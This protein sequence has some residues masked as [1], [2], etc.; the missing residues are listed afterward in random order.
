MRLEASCFSGTCNAGGSRDSVSVSWA[1]FSVLDNPPLPP[2]TLDSVTVINSTA[3]QIDFSEPVD[4]SNIL[5]Y[6]IER[7]NGTNYNVIGNVAQGTTTFDDVNLIPDTFYNY[8][9]IS[10]GTSENSNPSNIV[11]QRTTVILFSSSPDSNIGARW[12][13]GLGLAPC[14]DLTTF[15]CVNE[16]IRDDG[17]F[18]QTIG[19]GSSDSDID[20]F[21]MSDMED[22]LRSDSHFLKYTVRK[23]GVGTNPVEFEIILRQGVTTIATFTHTGLS[24]NYVLIQ[25]ELTGIQADLITDYNDLEIEVTGSCDAGCSNNPNAREK[26]NVSFIIFEIEQVTSPEIIKIDTLSSSSLRITWAIDEVDAEISDV[27]IQQ[28]NGTDFLVVG[29]VSNSISTFDHTGLESNKIIKYRLTGMLPGGGF[30]K[31]S[32]ESTGSTPPSTSS[33]T[34]NGTIIEPNANNSFTQNQKEIFAQTTE[35]YSLDRVSLNLIITDIEDNNLNAYE[36]INKMIDGSY[37]G[38]LEMINAGSFYANKYIIY[39][40]MN[41]FFGNIT[42]DVILGL[43]DSSD[44]GNVPKTVDEEDQ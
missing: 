22:P 9:V 21:T 43:D 33:L 35:H 38:T 30:S 18:I 4:T 7:F 25:Q 16:S 15:E 26:V 24:N 11:G 37:D 28:M 41:I 5:S 44:D 34:G 31:P 14:G 32:P 42:N 29:N 27:I 23:A 19:L 3:L 6:N 36:I 1:E 13:N 39:Q 17:D 40:D 20:S 12:V 8:R 2:P 10:V